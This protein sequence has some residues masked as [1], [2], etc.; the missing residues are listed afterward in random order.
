M[1][2]NDHIMEPHKSPA[3]FT[4]AIL[5]VVVL[6]KELLYRFVFKTGEDINS[7][8]VQSDAFHHQSAALNAIPH[9]IDMYNAMTAST[10][11]WLREHF[12]A[13]LTHCYT[14]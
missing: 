8:A 11:S 6:T 13:L 7:S 1:G 2:K 9:F 10:R 14:V 12:A 4:L 3:W 5:V